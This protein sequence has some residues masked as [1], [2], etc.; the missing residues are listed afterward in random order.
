MADWKSNIGD[1]LRIRVTPKASANRIKP[2]ILADGS[3]LL[4]VYVTVVPEDGKA[5]KAVIELLSDTLGI[6]KTRLRI[7]HGL[8][9]K[10]KTIRID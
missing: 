6:A 8:T 3:L 2:E 7:T 4:R 5:N 9:D 10:H 1:T